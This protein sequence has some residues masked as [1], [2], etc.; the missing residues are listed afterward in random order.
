M[1]GKPRNYYTEGYKASAV[2]RVENGETVSAVS[3]DLGIGYQTLWTWCQ[4][5]GVSVRQKR[6]PYKKHERCPM[7]GSSK[8]AWRKDKLGLI[9]LNAVEQART[10]PVHFTP[11]ETITEWN[12]D[13]EWWRYD[14]YSSE[15]ECSGCGYELRGD[16]DGGWFDPCTGKCAANF[17]PNC[18]HPIEQDPDV[19]RCSWFEG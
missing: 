5:R 16:D 17:C 18:G 4:E 9:D 6:P 1:T 8:N 7:C 15:W 2:S 14:P 12:G 11:M 10:E 19:L 3:K 13:E